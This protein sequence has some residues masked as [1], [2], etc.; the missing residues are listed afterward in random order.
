MSEA[1]HLVFGVD[2]GLNSDALSRPTHSSAAVVVA[3]SCEGKS[4][5]LRVGG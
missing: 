3:S 1:L 4:T 5:I 2:D